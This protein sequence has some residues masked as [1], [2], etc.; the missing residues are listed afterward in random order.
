MGK[1]VAYDLRGA[2][3]IGLIRYHI[4]AEAQGHSNLIS[5]LGVA[6]YLLRPLEARSQLFPMSL[7]LTIFA[8]VFVTELV[9]WIGKSVFLQFV[10]ILPLHL[11]L[12]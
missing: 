1:K 2:L 9:S 11:W 10:H 8:L 7:I 4:V 6:K 3:I 5:G 12:P